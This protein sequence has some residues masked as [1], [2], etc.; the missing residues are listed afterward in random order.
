MWVVWWWGRV[1]KTRAA[2]CPPPPRLPLLTQPTHLFCTAASTDAGSRLVAGATATPRRPGRGVGGGGAARAA[3]AARVAR[4]GADA[5]TRMAEGASRRDASRPGRRRG[6]VE[7]ECGQTTFRQ[8]L[9]ADAQLCCRVHRVLWPWPH[10][11]STHAA[12]SSTRCGGGGVGGRGAREKGGRPRMVGLLSSLSRRPGQQPAESGAGRPRHTHTA[13]HRRLAFAA[14]GPRWL[15]CKEE[16]GG[17]GGEER[18]APELCGESRGRR[19]NEKRNS[20]GGFTRGGTS[21]PARASLPPHQCRHHTP[22]L[23]LALAA[24][25]PRRAPAPPPAPRAPRPPQ[26]P[27][28]RR[29]PR[30]PPLSRWPTSSTLRISRWPREWWG[31]W[32]IGWG[33][34]KRRTCG[35]ASGVC[36]PSAR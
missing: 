30:P 12:W 17:V 27:P 24:P 16:R 20:R 8:H 11:T 36:C 13:T 31:R 18:N 4:A 5:A 28:R 9:R 26:P 6:W 2:R 29:L 25:A 34:R 32:P 21:R 35:A 22:A 14:R 15:S 7:C 1:N 33:R 23:H 10:G 19:Q 3:A